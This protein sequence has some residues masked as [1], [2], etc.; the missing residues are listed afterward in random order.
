MVAVIVYLNAQPFLAEAGARQAAFEAQAAAMLAR[1][2]A[3]AIPPAAPA[4]Q[5]LTTAEEVVAAASP[6][7]SAAGQAQLGQAL[8][9]LDA[10]RATQ[11]RELYQA[12][13]PAAA[14]SQAPVQ[15]FIASL[16]GLVT[17]RLTVVNALAARLP[18]AALGAL[19]RHPAVAQVLPDTV[20][21]AALETS[22]LSLRADTFWNA[23]YTGGVLDL[24]VIDTGIDHT[25]PAL[26][27]HGFAEG[28]FLSTAGAQA[29][30]DPAADDVN[31]HGTHVA[32]IAGSQDASRRGV[33][34]GLGTLLNGKAGYDTDGAAGG[35]ALMYESDSMA[36]VEWALFQAPDPAE[37]LNLSFAACAN[38]V[39]DTSWARFF[40]AV[41]A[42]TGVTVAVA[43]GNTGASCNRVT[44][45]SL[46]ANVI[47][48]ANVD[49]Q[50]TADRA[51]DTLSDT[52]LPGPTVAGRRK[53][54]LAAPGTS[55]N[56]ANAAW[57]GAGADFK[58]LSGTSMAAPHVAGAALL[59]MQSGVTDPRAIKALLINTA[60]DKGT[61][62]WDAGYGWGYV[63]LA[64]AFAHRGD[65]HPG[66]VSNAVPF[67]LY[68]G[69]ALAGDRATLA[70]QRHAAY[71]CAFP[72][73]QASSV[74]NL[75]LALY[76]AATNTL[77]DTSAAAAISDTVEQVE[78]PGASS[79][80]VVR[81]SLVSLNG[82][83]G[84][85]DFAL[86][87]EE[88]LTPA[89]GP[90]LTDSSA[91]VVARVSVPRPLNVR[92]ANTG[93]L[94]AHGVVLTVTVPSNVGLVAGNQV[95][96]VGV[97]DP[98]A[99]YSVPYTVTLQVDA[100]RLFTLTASATGYGGRYAL[101]DSVGVF[102]EH[103]RMWFP[104]WFGR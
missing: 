78:A 100:T 85:E 65:T 93:D 39:D 84:Q 57:E 54:D 62:G 79:L 8:A 67:R 56:S 59:L 4:L 74:S 42:A 40:D 26:I 25:H 91:G 30:T 81:V 6:A 87:T 23:G 97:L 1:V 103:V 83:L 38:T 61:A 34:F 45:P 89:V 18:A 48:V 20:A 14:A 99:V 86:A 5:P 77:L 96:N 41:V 17:T 76:A 21:Q 69:P 15:D 66:S 60:E 47:S 33:A 27:G 94:P 7:L 95:F 24:A 82:A 51:G 12:A 43:A 71:P 9:D 80:N 53:P 46:A 50:G 36:A 63:D 2:Q 92:L 64:H 13:R 11:R 98:G 68:K 102:P 58:L 72:C 55:I 52:S 37:A 104:L 10:L 75:D 49:D 19:E 90:V 101:S 88:G 3:A 31:G 29:T 16:G 32:G 35:A 44:S 70:W 73:S 22:P 28:R